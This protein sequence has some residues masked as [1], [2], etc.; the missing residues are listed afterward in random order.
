MLAPLPLGA[1]GHGGSLRTRSA[2]LPSPWRGGAPTSPPPR[3]SPAAPSDPS[4]L[5]H[6]PALAGHPGTDTLRQR[7]WNSRPWRHRQGR[8]RHRHRTRHRRDHRTSHRRPHPPHAP[9]QRDVRRRRALAAPEWRQTLPALL[10]VHLLP[11]PPHPN[12]PPPPSSRSVAGLLTV[13][14]GVLVVLVGCS[15]CTHSRDVHQLFDQI[16]QKEVN[17]PI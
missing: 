2:C 13:L 9:G 11:S 14:V 8:R 15:P 3:C 5:V 17:L 4:P 10:M 12:P 16:S 1:R 6:P 7:S